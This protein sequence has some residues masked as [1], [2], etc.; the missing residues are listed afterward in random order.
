MPM[1]FPDF[2]SLKSTAKVHHFRGP[3]EGES[4]ADFIKAL[5]LHVRLRDRIESIEIQFGVGWDKWDD[6]QK[7]ESLFS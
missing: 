5:A 2:E 3:H 6:N 7:R 1:D 4:E